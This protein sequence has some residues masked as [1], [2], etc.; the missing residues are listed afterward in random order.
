MSRGE[1]SRKKSRLD[2]LL[3]LCGT[4][5]QGGE[6]RAAMEIA[7]LVEPVANN[8]F[9]AR[10]GEPFGLAAEGATPDEALRK[11]QERVTARL[12]G[13]ARVTTITVGSAAHP[14]LPFAGTLKDDPLLEDWKR[15]ME[16][17]RQ[18]IDNDP[19][20]F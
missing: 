10:V 7:V 19:G 2:N 16:E 6:R 14:W 5:R 20:A 4:M 3:G 15:A 12:A 1:A 9:L 17:Y 11:L 8:G 18:S 13:G